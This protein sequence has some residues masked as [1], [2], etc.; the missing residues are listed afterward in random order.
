MSE[1]INAT[2]NCSERCAN[3]IGST[4]QRIYVSIELC[5]WRKKI[6]YYTRLIEQNNTDI[7][8]YEIT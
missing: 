6:C 1:N 3:R 8:R 4:L 7:E 5:S 2:V